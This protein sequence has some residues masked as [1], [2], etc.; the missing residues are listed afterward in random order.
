V[1]ICFVV[2][3]FAPVIGGTEGQIHQLA[4]GLAA[5]GH[6][7]EVVTQAVPGSPARE[8]LDGIAVARTI[9]TIPGGPLPGLTYGI[10][11]ALALWRRRVA[12]VFQVAFAHWDAAVA[13]WLRGA[14][15]RPV[16]VRVANTGAGGDLDRLR[17]SRYWPLI[18]SWDRPTVQALI[19][20]IQRCDAFVVP[21]PHMAA[22]LVREGFPPERIAQIKNG[23]DH[24]RFRPPRP[25][26]RAATR[27]AL[28]LETAR[29][30]VAVGRLES[31]KGMGDLI[32]AL[33]RLSRD[34]HLVLAGDGSERE[35]LR[36]RARTLGVTQ[37]IH[38]VGWAEDVVPLLWAGDVFAL[39]SHT[40]GMPNALL[41]AMATG[42]PC[43][44]TSVGTVAEVL[45]GGDAGSLV[46]PRDPAALASALT[47]LLED[48]S[49]AARLGMAARARIE[50]HYTLA[51]MLKRYE[52][53]YEALARPPVGRIRPGEA[54]KL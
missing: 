50:G 39:P 7:V 15:S 26:E 8:R 9:R 31:W 23:V 32:T 6:T 41:E 51:E 40:E 21:V 37:R 3:Q 49:A 38:L 44:A 54:K 4:A 35:L 27:A 33:P 14:L 45:G 11:L 17:G 34:T 1:R 12:D 19:R 29:V 24:R 53:L 46:P 2:S 18:R 43:V 30:V 42:L 16:V 36:S 5:R 20:A 48:E 25:E 28:G 47:A 52:G 13:G 10:S 22:A